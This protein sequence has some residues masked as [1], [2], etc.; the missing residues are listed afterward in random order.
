MEAII[1]VIRLDVLRQGPWI[2]SVVYC[3]WHCHKLCSRGARNVSK[4]YG[5]TITHSRRAR[6]VPHTSGKERDVFFFFLGV[7]GQNEPSRKGE[8]GFSCMAL[9]TQSCFA[10]NIPQIQRA[11]THLVQESCWEFQLCLQ[12]HVCRLESPVWSVCLCALLDF[13]ETLHWIW[14]K[15]NCI[16]NGK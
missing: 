14:T 15:A 2:V 9:M 1:N 3:L 12:P 7:F 10:W 13:Y 16:E 8:W 5:E 6:V 4:I 11:K